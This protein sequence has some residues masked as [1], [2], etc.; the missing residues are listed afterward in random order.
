MATN[1]F[2]YENASKCYAVLMSETYTSID[3]DG[4][5]V[6]ELASYDAFDYYS[7]IDEIRHDMMDLRKSIPNLSFYKDGS[8]RHE[9]RSYPSAIIGT[10][11]KSE[12]FLG[13]DVEVEITSVIRSGYYDGACLDYCYTFRFDGHSDYQDALETYVSDMHSDAE[14]ETNKRLAEDFLRHWTDV[15]SDEL[16]KIFSSYSS[17]LTKVATASNGE[18]FYVNANNN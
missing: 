17:P 5:Q 6:E 9:L 1:N 16:E 12:R 14:I 4:N 7:L 18:T 2:H 13:V 8:D 15:L 11:S 3:E 10:L